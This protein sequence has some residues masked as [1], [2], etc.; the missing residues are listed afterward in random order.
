MF[1]MKGGWLL[2]PKSRR[3]I[4]GQRLTIMVQAM[5]GG[6]ALINKMSLPYFNYG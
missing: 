2:P 1:G 6:L 5:W 3:G 4:Y